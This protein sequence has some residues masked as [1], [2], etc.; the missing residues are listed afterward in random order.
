MLKQALTDS[1]SFFQNHISAIALIV[2]PIAAPV[3]IVTALYLDFNTSEDFVLSEQLIPLTIWLAA[4]PIYTAG[5]VFYIASVISGNVITTKTAWHL[6]IRFWLPFTIMNSLCGLIIMGGMLFFI[7]PGIIF[8]VR[9]AFAQFDLLLNQSSPISAMKVS[10]AA[11]RDYFWPVL[12]GYLVISVML[13]T[14]YI[15]LIASVEETGSFYWILETTLNI[16]YAV[17]T[18]F[19]TIFAFRIYEFSRTNHASSPGPDTAR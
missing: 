6:G 2:L 19:Y 12:G 7:I 16:A 10:W 13:Y 17:L 3:E 14:P 18:T 15:L 5:V 11:T 8:A 4:F 9:Y 1:W